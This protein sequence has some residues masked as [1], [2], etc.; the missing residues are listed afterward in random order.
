MADRD[1][2]GADDPIPSAD[3]EAVFSKVGAL[4]WKAC[5]I[6]FLNFMNIFPAALSAVASIIIVYMVVSGVKHPTSESV[7]VIANGF[8]INSATRVL[9][10]K[11]FGSLSDYVGR[12]P[13]M[14]W[15]ALV[16]VVSR[17][18]LVSATNEGEIYIAG[19]IYGLDV[20][21]PV[22]QAWLAD[23]VH[24]EE[25]GKSYGIFAGIGFGL[26]FAVGIPAGA[27]ISQNVNERLPIYI[28][29][30]MQVALVILALFAPIPDTLGIKQSINP[31]YR[32]SPTDQDNLKP[33]TR[34][35]PPDIK[36]FLYENSI[37]PIMNL[38]DPD[39]V[40]LRARE[41]SWDYFSYFFA[42]ASQQA[43]QNAFIP[44][45]Q[46]AY[47]YNQTQ[48]G[49]AL[50]FV[51]V[52]VGLFAPVVLNY[53]Q[54]RP[55]TFWAIIVQIAASVLFTISGLPQA[56]LNGAG[57]GV[58]I[59]AMFLIAAGGTW[60]PAFPSVITK[61]YNVDDKGEVLGTLAL[62]AEASNVLAYPVGVML[63]FMLSPESSI[64]WPGAIWLVT[65]SY[66]VVATTCSIKTMGSKAYTLAR[67][68]KEDKA[69]EVEGVE[70]AAKEISNPLSTEGIEMSDSSVDSSKHSADSRLRIDDKGREHVM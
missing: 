59:A 15:S 29:M 47:H 35:P 43:L 23:I 26:A 12:K 30:I 6:Y 31:E 19:F 64:R 57:P 68:V 36:A 52:S 7:I 69:S 2:K 50:A 28:G 65:G 17:G 63:A 55:V 11:T 67:V 13:L 3:D 14:I 38:Y 21:S 4:N 37:F 54:D 5:Y 48:A 8:L 32:G 44:F 62:L 22:A 66:L 20:F 51:A 10:S 33:A 16:W 41:N 39:N 24:D 60:I 25:R 27:V 42:Q 49:A 70:E 18:F 45:V 58:G 46:A 56:S 1:E 53:Y 9:F 34:R 40:I 61:Q